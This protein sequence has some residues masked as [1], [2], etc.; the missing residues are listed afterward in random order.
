MLGKQLKE[1]CILATLAALVVSASI[2]LLVELA[3]WIWNLA[4]R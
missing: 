4:T 3:R 2:G 1:W